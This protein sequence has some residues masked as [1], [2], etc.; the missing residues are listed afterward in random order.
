ILSVLGEID[1][2]CGFT[3]AELADKSKLG[4]LRAQHPILDTLNIVT[5]SDAHYLENMREAENFFDLE[6][7]TRENVIN[8]LDI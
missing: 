4:A 1:E 5:N 7:L 3:T 2:S 6:A 8:Y